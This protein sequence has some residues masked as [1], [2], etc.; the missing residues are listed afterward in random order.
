MNDE[1]VAMQPEI[2]PDLV[3][4]PLE[5]ETLVFDPETSLVHLLDETT[6]QTLRRLQEGQE[7]DDS[8]QESLGLEELARLGLLRGGLEQAISRRAAL[9]RLAK[10]AAVPAVLS[11]L[12]PIPAAAASVGTTTD[13][14]CRSG[15]GNPCGKTCTDAGFPTLRRCGRAS[16]GDFCACQDATLPLYCSADGITYPQC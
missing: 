11:V 14:L 8:D 13:L 12:A 4:T 2:R 5:Q 1:G 7:L 10:V 16:P 9:A 3:I 6:S 15:T